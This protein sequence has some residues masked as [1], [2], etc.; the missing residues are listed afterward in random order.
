MIKQILDDL[1]KESYE[2]QSSTCALSWARVIHEF[3]EYLTKE[4]GEREFI[5]KE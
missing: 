3:H 4:C 1:F 2:E 5:T